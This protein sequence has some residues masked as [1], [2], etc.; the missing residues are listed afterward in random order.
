[1]NEEYDE[2][3]KAAYAIGELLTTCLLHINEE[4]MRRRQ[5]YIWERY[6]LQ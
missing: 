2:E 5:L 3:Q 4:P 6:G 1:M